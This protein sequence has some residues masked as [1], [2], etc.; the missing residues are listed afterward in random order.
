MC[1]GFWHVESAGQC[2]HL[3]S[4]KRHLSWDISVWDVCRA[5][6]T[7]E[8]WWLII[9]GSYSCSGQGPG[10]DWSILCWG[11]SVEVQKTV[12]TLLQGFIHGS[13]D[14]CGSR[15]SLCW[16]GEEEAG[17]T[18]LQPPPAFVGMLCFTIYG[19][20]LGSAVRAAASLPLLTD[21]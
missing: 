3:V 6:F 16:V 8:Q 18:R 2:V 1:L 21:T 13:L 10:N 7:T 17:K 4:S 19:G 9:A 14:H 15:M 11:S 12:I 20:G 5:V